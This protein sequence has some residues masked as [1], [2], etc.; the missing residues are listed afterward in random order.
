MKNPIYTLLGAFVLV[1]V[2]MLLT[3]PIAQDLVYHRFADTL[4]IGPIP[5]FWNVISNFPFCV[6]GAVGILV[7]SKSSLRGWHKW[8]WIILFVGVFL[9]GIGSSWYH[10][11]PTNDS[12]VWDR[13]PMVVI[14][15]PFFTICLHYYF[16]DKWLKPGLL[17]LLPTGLFSVIYWAYTETIGTGDLRLYALVQ[18]FPM[19][20]LT[21]L[22][23]IKKTASGFRKLLLLVMLSYI[24]AKFC[25]H[26][27][28]IIDDVIGFSGHSLKHLFAALATWFMVRIAILNTAND[29]QNE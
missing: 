1:L 4:K 22:L 2:I 10:L 26:F 13:L 20:A 3:G 24:S 19:V 18:F 8:N 17:I 15:M 14:F 23:V 21:V 7:I 5:N 9:T 28:T 11:D 16:G 12:L 6:T 25:E 29:E 27:D